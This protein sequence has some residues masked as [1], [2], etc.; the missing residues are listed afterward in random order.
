MWCK[1]PLT[2][3]TPK[4]ERQEITIDWKPSGARP[5]ISGDGAVWNRSLFNLLDNALSYTPPGGTVRLQLSAKSDA[6]SHNSAIDEQNAP[7]DDDSFVDESDC[8]QNAPKLSSTKAPRRAGH[9][10][11]FHADA[12]PSVVWK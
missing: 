5:T 7:R 6:A 11:G 10:N 4:A 8:A 9:S 12:P 2:A 1:A 3:C